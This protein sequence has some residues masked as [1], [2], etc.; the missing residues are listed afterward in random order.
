MLCV[1]ALDTSRKQW[2][3]TLRQQEERERRALAEFIMQVGATLEVEAVSVA[4]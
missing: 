2:K 3:K 1:L 4:R